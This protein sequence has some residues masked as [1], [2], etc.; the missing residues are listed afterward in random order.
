MSDNVII[1]SEIVLLEPWPSLE[2]SAK[3]V[4]GTSGFASLDIE[5]TIFFLLS[6]LANL[7]SSPQPGGPGLCVH[8][9][10]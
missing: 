5:R 10:P 7:A 4:Y 6:K 8:V 9:P 3:F 1:I 2:N